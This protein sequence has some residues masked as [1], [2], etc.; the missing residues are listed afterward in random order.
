ML[1]HIAH[2]D[3]KLALQGVEVLFHVL[4]E[5]ARLECEGQQSNFR[6]V[7][8]TVLEVVRSCQQERVHY[9][10]LEGLIKIMQNHQ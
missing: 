1:I 2:R 8:N 10:V 3:L 6:L 7:F 4:L 5:L 9:A